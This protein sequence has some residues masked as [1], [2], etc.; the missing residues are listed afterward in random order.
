MRPVARGGRVTFA[1]WET[2]ILALVILTFTRVHAAIGNNVAAATDNA[3]TL[4]TVERTLHL[5]IELAM[6]RWLVGHDALIAPSVIVYR[7]YYA[8]LI[9]VVVWI[10]LRHPGVYRHVRNTFIAMSGLAL[11][12]YWAVPMSPPRFALAGIVDVITEHDLW[13]GRAFHESG[14]YTA[15]PSVHV[16]WSAWA[17]YAA[18]SA[19]RGA[20]PRGALLVWMFP[21]VMVA[22]VFSTGSHYV[23]DVV[24][25]ALLL[26]LSIAVARLWDRLARHRARASGKD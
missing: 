19:L 25:S 7:G 3:R 18:W 15:M 11:L 14:S 16:A 2:S 26:V 12:V 21:S 23:L 22:V 1:L 13:G 5:N 8:V 4:Q 6:N 20:H 10:F 9:G 24:G 17:A